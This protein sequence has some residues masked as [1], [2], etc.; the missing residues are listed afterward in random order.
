[1]AV[2]IQPALARAVSLAEDPSLFNR[3]IGAKCSRLVLE[4]DVTTRST[5]SQGQEALFVEKR[6]IYT[7]TKAT[8]EVN[9]GSGRPRV[10]SVTFAG[11]VDRDTAEALVG[12]A[13]EPAK[14]ELILG[15]IKFDHPHTF[16]V[17]LVREARVPRVKL[18]VDDNFDMNPAVLRARCMK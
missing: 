8:N 16:T 1:M 15:L 13:A 4:F 12:R 3:A 11:A 7:A 9:V 5:N 10:H 17:E 6:L 18:Y 2:M 14:R